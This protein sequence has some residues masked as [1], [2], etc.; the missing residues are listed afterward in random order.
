[1]LANRTLKI[2]N[3][4]PP[5]MMEAVHPNT[6]KRD[7]GL[8]KVARREMDMS[9]AGFSEEYFDTLSF[10]SVKTGGSKRLEESCHET[11]RLWWKVVC[12]PTSIVILILYCLFLASNSVGCMLHLGPLLVQNEA[13][14]RYDEHVSFPNCNEIINLEIRKKNE[15]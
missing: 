8:C 3:T 5:T 13:L 4:T 7:S 1:M 12:C 14:I 15:K 9:D 11:N 6:R 10:E 2:G